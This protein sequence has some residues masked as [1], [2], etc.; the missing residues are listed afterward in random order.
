MVGK[1][2]ES[3][4]EDIGR[5][6]SL[7]FSGELG[8]YFFLIVSSALV[9]NFFGA[10]IFGQYTYIISFL[11][12]I[13]G[14]AKLGMGDAALYFIPRHDEFE[15]KE[16]TAAVTAFTYMVVSAVSA[17][18]TLLII[19]FSVP[20]S[21]H[22]LNSRESSRLLIAMAPLVFIETLYGQ[23]MSVFRARKRIGRYSLIRNIIYHVVRISAV[24]IVFL[25]FGIR[26]VYGIVIPTYVSYLFVLAYS[27]WY[28]VKESM[29]GNPRTLSG[30]EKIK[31]VRYGLPLF[32]AAIIHVLLR[33]ADILMI[34]YII[35]PGQVAVYNIAVQVCTIIPFFSVLANVFFNP[36]VSS[37]HHA[38]KRVEMIGTYQAVSKWM[39]ASGLFI[40]LGLMLFS[41]SVLHLFGTEFIAGSTALVLVGFGALAGIIT[42]PSA[43]M[44][45][46]TGH[47]QFNLIASSITFTVNIILNLVLIPRHGINGAAVATLISAFTGG[48]ISLVFLYKKQKIQPY[49]WMHL[50]PLAAGA[51]SYAVIAMINRHIMW[52]GMTDVII[53]AVLYAALFVG[54]MI[55]LGFDD[56]DRVILKNL[57]KGFATIA[58]KLKQAP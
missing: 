15:Q 13:M 45:A 6:A 9:T 23:T 40:F 38:G 44:N 27:L 35:G 26:N 48:I 43:G 14:I 58:R 17:F 21:E 1:K 50:K 24:L 46:M 7:S 53:K 34:G 37:L 56:D 52:Q 47:P 33:Q 5:F 49:T 42:G 16:K 36:M 11:T 30:T 4:L 29:I 12:I 57:V 31:M 55:L 8:K 41:E 19:F 54:V 20:I 2:D 3:H 22:L 25:I 39:F 28:Q 32:M 10:E 18:L 51:A